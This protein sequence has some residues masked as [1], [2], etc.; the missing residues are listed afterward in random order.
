MGMHYFYL[1]QFNAALP[2]F[3]EPGDEIAQA[4]RYYAG[5][6]P[7]DKL[8]ST[9]QVIDVLDRI[10]NMPDDQKALA[11]TIAYLKRQGRL[12]ERARVVEAYLRLLNPEWTDGW[13][14]YNMAESRLKIGGEGLKKISTTHTTLQSLQPRILDV[15]GSE[16]DRMWRERTLAV[17]TVDVRGARWRMS[18]F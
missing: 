6:S 1:H 3:S 4:A 18:G 14:E 10:K 9:D 16:V 15:S 7:D 8:L 5:I 11:F 17:E 13:F 12:E 2:Y